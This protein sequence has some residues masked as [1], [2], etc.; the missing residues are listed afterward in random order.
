MKSARTVKS[1]KSKMMNPYQMGGGYHPLTNPNGTKYPIDADV[2][3]MIQGRPTKKEAM[4]AG[5]N[6]VLAIPDNDTQWQ[7]DSIRY[8]PGRENQFGIPYVRD[9]LRVKGIA[10]G[11]KSD[12][13]INNLPSNKYR[14]YQDSTYANVNGYQMGGQAQPM[15]EAPQEQMQD[16]A[17]EGSAPDQAQ[18]Q[19]QAGG[20]QMQQMM[21]AVMQM[22][23]QGISP[24]QIMQKL[25]Q[26][27]VPQE[28]AQQLVQ[29]AMQQ[30][31]G[32]QMRMGGYYR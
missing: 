18:D 23:Q 20:D 25:V 3:A 31:Q 30:S 11:S 27:G 22:L 28:Q 15:Q 12:F 24:E 2:M 32:A 29:Q 13:N 4:L 26:S 19:G 17:P 14:M 21:Q 16:T 5:R 9:G 1:R 6:T 8:F 10:P 7:G